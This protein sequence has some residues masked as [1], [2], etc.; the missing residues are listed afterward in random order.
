M[1]LGAALQCCWRTTGYP[2][3]NLPGRHLWLVPPTPVR[4][5]GLIAGPSHSGLLWFYHGQGRNIEVATS[6]NQEGGAGLR[7]GQARFAS[8]Y[9]EHEV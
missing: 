2:L 1:V 9:T 7:P 4:W 8:A 5:L 3:G 6:R